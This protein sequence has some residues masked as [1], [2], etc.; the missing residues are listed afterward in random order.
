MIVLR[1][2]NPLLIF[3]GF[4]PTVAAFLLFRSIVTF[5]VLQHQLEEEEGILSMLFASTHSL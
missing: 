3:V 4:K 5:F 1:E 2:S